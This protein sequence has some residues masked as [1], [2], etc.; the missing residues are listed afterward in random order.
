MTTNPSIEVLIHEMSAK[1]EGLSAKFGGLELR[2]TETRDD[3]REARDAATRLTAHVQAQDMSGKLAELKGEMTAGFVGARSDLVNATTTLTR[4]HRERFAETDERF[5]K[6]D[7]RFGRLEKRTGDL[8]SLRDQAKGAGVLVTWISKNAPWLL[9]IIMS[10][11][12]ALGWKG[13]V[14]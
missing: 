14:L 8:E 2:V 10:A 13:R 1:F 7:E 4:E 12:A 3:A 11:A 6:H 9:L 5:S